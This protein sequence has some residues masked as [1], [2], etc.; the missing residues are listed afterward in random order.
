MKDASKKG[1]IRNQYSDQELTHC[2]QGHPFDEENTFVNSR[3]TKVCKICNRYFARINQRKRNQ[4][5]RD[6]ESSET[7]D[8]PIRRSSRSEYIAAL[9]VTRTLEESPT[10]ASHGNPKIIAAAK[11]GGDAFKRKYESDPEFAAAWRQANAAASNAGRQKMLKRRVR[12]DECGFISN[13][14]GIGHHQTSLRHSGKTELEPLE[15]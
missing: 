5:K 13:P 2:P 15:D 3:G 10:P 12:C 9:D 6:G 14:S 7:T 1:R 4:R 8:A 11:S